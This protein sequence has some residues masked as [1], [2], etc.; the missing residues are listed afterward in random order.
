MADDLFFI[1]M[2]AKALEDSNPERAMQAAFEEIRELGRRS[3][4]RRGL[5]QFEAFLAAVAGAR[6]P[7]S[8]SE[9]GSFILER[10][11]RGPLVEITVERNG[12]VLSACRFEHGTG[13]GTIK[14]LQPGR[15]LFKLDTGRVLWEGELTQ[16]DLIWSKAHPCEDLAVAADTGELPDPP[17]RELLLLETTL[18]VR[19]QP[20]LEAG[21]LEIRL[22]D[23]EGPA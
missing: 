14:D 5:K 12:E 10:F 15:Y 22:T 19:V 9:T 7:G 18:R 3:R 6:F 4:Y 11:D 17:T 16:Q 2:I 20:G 1:P 13:T 21:Q 23:A 8:L